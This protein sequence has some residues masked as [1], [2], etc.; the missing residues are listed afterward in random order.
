MKAGTVAPGEELNDGNT[1][2]AFPCRSGQL[3]SRDCSKYV[4]ITANRPLARDD[5]VMR[6]DA[7]VDMSRQ[8]M[9]TDYVSRI[10]SLLKRSGVVIPIDSS[11]EISHHYGLERYREVGLALIDCVNREY[12]KKILVL[13]PGQSHPSHRHVRKEETF[14]VVYGDLTVR[15]GDGERTMG[16]GETMVMERNVPHGFYSAAGCVFEEISSTHI[17]GDSF[18]ERLDEFV[19]PRKTTVYLTR[20]VLE[21]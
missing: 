7:T 15:Y 4:R 11:C 18:Y 21:F 12:C 13:L 17:A 6:D 3:V 14:L 8:R 10:V 20:S 19:S 2:F 1:Y 5:A 16:R 9:V